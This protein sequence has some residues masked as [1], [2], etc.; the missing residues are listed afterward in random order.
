VGEVPTVGAGAQTQRRLMAIAQAPLFRGASEQERGQLAASARDCAAARREVFVVQGQPAHE[1][2]LLCAGRVKLTQVSADGQEFILR[3]VGPGEHFGALGVPPGDT[4][5]ATAEALEPSQALQW[6]R[7]QL[8]G[9]VERSPVL[10]ANAL[11]IVSQRLRSAEERCREMATERVAQR[12]AR[13]LFRLLGHVGR[14]SGGAVYVSLTREE[15]AQ[16][17][18]TTLF[19]V[20]RLFSRWEA[21]GLIRPRREG[22]LID[23]AAGLVRVADSCPLERHGSA[24]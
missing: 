24:S 7:R 16:M 6:A 10:H 14:P 1:S 20:S 22:V 5:P 11:R 12:V 17:T 3:L 13:T 23:D 9:L 15:L 18:G 2:F 4:H 21:E 8:D 19:T